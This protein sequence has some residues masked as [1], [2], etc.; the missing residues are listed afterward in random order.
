MSTLRSRFAAVAML[1]LVPTLAAC[2]FNEQTDAIYQASTCTNARN[3]DVWILNA[4][5]VSATDGTGTF[6]GTLVN[7]TETKTVGLTSVTD[8]VGEPAIKVGP[9]DNVNLA[10]SGELRLKGDDIVPGKF[11]ALTFTFDNGETTTFKVPVVA[12]TDDYAAVPVGPTSTPTPNA[13]KVGK[14]AKN[15]GKKAASG[16]PSSTASPSAG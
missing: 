3:G 4:T 1:L 16:S 12:N 11:V 14:T 6:A 2:G 9:S 8:A 15:K 5:I 13:D 7:Q 10:R